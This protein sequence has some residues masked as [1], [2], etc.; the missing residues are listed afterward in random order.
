M[1]ERGDII[2]IKDYLKVNRPDKPNKIFIVIANIDGSYSVLSAVT[3][4]IYFN[5]NIKYGIIKFGNE[6][7]LFCF[8]SGHIIG[9]NGFAFKKDTFIYLSY[10]IKRLTQEQLSLYNIEIKDRINDDI[11]NEL[12]EF[13][14]PAIKGKEKQHIHKI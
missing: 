9:K 6:G 2:I 8:P 3:S 5:E 4:Q 7:K 10:N 1:I 11:Y 12:I 13:L 14:Y